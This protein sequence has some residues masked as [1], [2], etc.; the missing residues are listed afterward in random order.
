MYVVTDGAP[1]RGHPALKELARKALA[2]PAFMRPEAVVRLA[3]LP[4][5]AGVGKVLRRALDNAT[6]LE[7]IELKP[8]YHAAQ[9][10]P[11]LLLGEGAGVRESKRQ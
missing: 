5:G 2:L 4:R 11:S 7:I 3:E 1:V 10:D 8:L 9:V 6:P